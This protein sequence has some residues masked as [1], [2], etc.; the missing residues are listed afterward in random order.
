[1]HLRVTYDGPALDSHEMDVRELAPALL[2]IADAF[3]LIGGEV[4]GDRGIVQVRVRGSFQ[5]GSF[6]VDLLLV[7][8]LA[9]QLMNLLTSKP[10]ESAEGLSGLVATFYGLWRFFRRKGNKEILRLERRAGQY[11]IV[12]QDES[13]LEVEEMMM[14]LLQ[15]SAVIEALQRAVA[16]LRHEGIHQVA[17]GTDHVIQEIIT[18]DEAAN[19]LPISTPEEVLIDDTRRMALSLLSIS[20]KED[21]KWRVWDGQTAIYVSM[22]DSAFLDRIEKGESF[23]KGDLLIGQV[24]VRQVNRDNR[25]HAEYSLVEVLE[26]RHS[27][28]QGAFPFDGAEG[29]KRR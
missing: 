9:T 7:Q 24:R 10:A 2:A 15:N 4:L 27:P 11:I 19:V 13:E 23:A 16:P 14:R 6:A 20:F 22:E 21:N 5:T 1:M 12:F 29:D 3:D 25:L 26:H 18:K 17:F 28:Q 8:R